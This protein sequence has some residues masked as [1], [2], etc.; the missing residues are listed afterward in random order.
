M[1]HKS[2][3]ADI[4]KPGYCAAAK[5]RKLQNGPG[6]LM[7]WTSERNVL[8]GMIMCLR[9]TCMDQQAGGRRDQPSENLKCNRIG[10]NHDGMKANDYNPAY[11]PL[12]WLV[13][14]CLALGICAIRILFKDITD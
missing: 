10:W 5:Y 4:L 1:L 3:D 6:G 2:H 8:A 13:G 7:V 11:L 12:A 9:S 14:I